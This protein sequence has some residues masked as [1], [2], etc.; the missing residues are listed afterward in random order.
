MPQNSE[1]SEQ[2]RRASEAEQRLRRRQHFRALQ[3]R[4]ERNTGPVR[5]PNRAQ[6]P[7]NAFRF[8]LKKNPIPA[9]RSYS[10]VFQQMREINQKRVMDILAR[11]VAKAGS[12]V[13]LGARNMRRN[14]TPVFCNAR[15]ALVALPIALAGILAEA[16]V[17]ALAKAMPRQQAEELVKKA[18]AAASP[19]TAD[20]STPDKPRRVNA[21]APSTK[22]AATVTAPTTG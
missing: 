20:E 13:R 10:A 18:C 14:F 8:W 21:S 22:P 4:G 3:D 2:L 5:V 1:H 11:A 17:F 9:D 15:P 6:F 7:L 16:A 12:Y 19:D